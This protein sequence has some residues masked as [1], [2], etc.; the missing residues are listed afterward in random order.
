M[1]T[2]SAGLYSGS[3]FAQEA[4]P[5]VIDQELMD[6]LIKMAKRLSA[7]ETFTITADVNSEIVLES[8]ERLTTVDQITANVRTPHHLR[9][10]RTSPTRERILYYD[11]ADAVL[12]GPLTGYYTKV[13]FTGTIAELVGEMDEKYAYELPLADLFLW[14]R[15]PEE[16]EVITEAGFVGISNIGGRFCAQYAYRSEA[17]D[18][19]LWIEMD[20][21]GMP[22]RYQIIDKTDEARPTFVATVTIATYVNIDDNRFT[23]VPPEDAVSIPFEPVEAEE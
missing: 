1:L 4:E 6:A 19:Q 9:M 2:L 21:E 12:W 5:P 22:C 18:L 8:G 7:L 10:E 11:G 20:D 16:M 3:T 15:D 14:G 13:P 23:F 17:A